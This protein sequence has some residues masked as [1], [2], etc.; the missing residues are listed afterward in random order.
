MRMTTSLS[1]LIVI[2]AILLLAGCAK[3]TPEEM[4][5]EA[6]ALLAQN[7]T[8]EA[9][10]KFE[11]IIEKHPQSPAVTQARLGLA[12]IYD[13]QRNFQREREQ[14]DILLKQFKGPATESGWVIFP[15]KIASYMREGKPQLALREAIETSAT[16]RQAPPEG[17]NV[18]Q[19]MLSDLYLYNNDTTASL[20]ILEHQ[21]QNGP[22]DPRSQYEILNRK[23]NILARSKAWEKINENNQAYIKRFPNVPLKARLLF[24]IGVNYQENIK[25]QARADESF[26][27]SAAAAKEAYE[28]GVGAD[29]KC[30]SLMQLAGL[31]MYRGQLDKEE[32]V[33][34][35]IIKEFPNNRRYR[36]TALFSLA[37]L[38]MTR[39]QPKIAIEKLSEITKLYP[40]SD[41]A[42]Q[43]AATIRQIQTQMAAGA[44][45]G[46]LTQPATGTGA[47]TGTAPSQKSPAATPAEAGR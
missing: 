2:G 3:K 47:T 22:N 26:E 14:Y 11:D 34:N 4:L 29:E 33:L 31:Y 44:T 32:Q 10:I 17:K 28:K 45:T 37:Q 20:G 8:L 16:F 19:V 6:D 9:Q 25:D 1:R 39:K 12:Q 46:T 24:Q 35:Q 42:N 15:M 40:N 27:A 5:K 13:N 7:S 43:A 18:F 41:E 38:E 23:N 36:A 30:E 21:V